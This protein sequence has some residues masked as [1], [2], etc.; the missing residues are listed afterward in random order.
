MQQV[1]CKG[2]TLGVYTGSGY[3]AIAQVISLD[4]PEMETETYEADY[5]A[6]TVPGIPYLPTGR[7]EGGKCSGELW[8]DPASYNNNGHTTLLTM[9]NTI[10]AVPFQSSGVPV[11]TPAA[12]TGGWAFYQ[13]TFANTDGG[14]GGTGATAW[15]F[16]GAGLSLGGTVALKEGLKG[17]FSIKLSGLP[18]FGN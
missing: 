4:V 1:K 3:T 5:L 9:L 10:P 8:L 11:A 14:S 15:T 17:K 2:T 16:V 12:P 18:T 7:T 13:L 6:N